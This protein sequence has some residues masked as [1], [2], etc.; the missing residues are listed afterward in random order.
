MKQTKPLLV[1]LPDTRDVQI[2]PY[3]RGNTK[4][5]ASVYTYSRVAGRDGELGTCPGSTN[6]CE[7]WCYAKRIRGVVLEQ[8]KV[9]SATEEV[10]PIPDDCRLLRIHVSGDFT[11]PTYVE[12]WITR[13]LQRPDVT[14]WAYT[15]S[16][17]LP[18][19]R[20]SLERLRDLPNMQ[21]FASMDT[22]MEAV[23]VGWRRAWIEGDL[24]LSVSPEYTIYG[25]GSNRNLLVWASPDERWTTTISR[26]YVCPE[27]TGHKAN[28]EEC[29]Y[30]FDGRVHDVVFL[31][32]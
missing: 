31:K 30:C 6:E 23:P 27:E 8:Y 3:M 18:W 12:N 9:N 20:P 17:R 32:H 28:C 1:V 29:R 16:W 2:S 13:L 14:A 11:S 24:R 25:I 21:L 15:R 10:P 4:L 22:E 19:L 7:T 5:G 26:G